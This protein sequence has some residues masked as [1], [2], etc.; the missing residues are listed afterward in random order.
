M[1]VKIKLSTIIITLCLI[2]LA[3]CI[4]EIVKIYNEENRDYVVAPPES[5]ADNKSVRE[6]DD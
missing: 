3:V 1:A 6:S 5:E 2:G 4:Y